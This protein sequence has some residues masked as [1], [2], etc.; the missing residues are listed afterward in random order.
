MHLGNLRTALLAWLQARL[1]GGRFLLRHD[2]L[3]LPRRRPGAIEAIESDLNWLGLSWDGP[4]LRQSDRTGLYASVLSA[5]RRGGVLYPCRCSRRMLAD[6]SAPHGG[7]PLYPGTC[8][9]RAVGWGPRQGRLP[10]WRLRLEPGD[11]RWREEIG[12]TGCLE[13]ATQVGDV[14]L[15][16]ADG[17]LAYHLTSA[18]DDLLMGVTT[19]VR[20]ADL[21]RS[22]A[23][24]VAVCERLGRPF[25]SCWHV[26]LWLDEGGQRLAKRQ[27]AQGLEPLRREGLDA[28]AVI[29]RMAASLALV[30][31][32]S[33]LSAVDLLQELDLA[34]LQAQLRR[35]AEDL[36]TLK[37]GFGIKCPTLRSD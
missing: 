13:A 31:A 10:S 20:G 30:P 5:F 9:D 12:P 28:A 26:P 18:V 2:D 7:W 4:S 35:G 19:V 37:E 27:A 21:W 17:F 3:D 23:P 15:R 24:Q 29:G 11:L 33:R 36:G 22:T 34:H 8:R 1:S 16:R 25:V 14:V 32:G 6:L